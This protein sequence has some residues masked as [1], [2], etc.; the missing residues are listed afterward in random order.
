MS[1]LGR[2]RGSWQNK[3]ADAAGPYLDGASLYRLLED[4]RCNQAAAVPTVFMGLLQY[5]RDTNQRF[6]HLQRITIG[7]AACP[8][9][10]IQACRPNLG[11]I[12]ICAQGS[13]VIGSWN[14]I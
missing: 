14:W 8:A 3:R 2:S 5:V 12:T 10:L 7:G 6:T 9:M 13:A 4:E 1:G 11:A